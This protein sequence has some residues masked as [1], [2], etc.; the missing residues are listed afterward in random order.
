MEILLANFL[1]IGPFQGIALLALAVIIMLFTSFSERKSVKIFA[2]TLSA[3]SYA[4]TLYLFINNYI[5]TGLFEDFLVVVA[6]KELILL[7]IIIFCALNILFYISFYRFY[8]GGFTRIIIILTF[9]LISASFLVIAS[10]FIIIFVSLVITVFN[11][12]AIISSA[13]PGN[14]ESGEAIGKFGIRTIA[15]PVL[16]FFGFSVLYGSGE[17]KSFLEVQGLETAGDPFILIGTI[18]FA[19]GLFL[20]LFLYPFQGPYLRLARRINGETLPV[21]WFL[22][23]PLGIIMFIKFEVFF[24]IFLKQASINTIAILAAILLLSL[25]GA[26]I[27]ALRTTS[28]KRIIS[29]LMLFS[30]GNIIF[31]KVLGPPGAESGAGLVGANIEGLVVMIIGFMPVCLLMIFTEKGAGSDSILNL[32]GF[33]YR[34]IY[35]SICIILVL[36]WWIAASIYIS[37]LS[38]LFG[39]GSFNYPGTA[40]TI[41]LALYLASWL[42]TAFN[43]SRITFAL[44]SRKREKD[45]LKDIPLPKV[46]YIY[47]SIF[48]LA[49]I[50]TVLLSWQGLLWFGV[51]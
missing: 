23:I 48:T 32:R 47:F 44:F 39:G 27:G 12:F 10:N 3:L 34:K 50:S 36:L 20:F 43:I 40:K 16:F 19:C 13:G 41:I 46:F 15:A 1:K 4:G 29:M 9:T 37:P 7:G 8:K 25:F 33:A 30:V 11:I 18:V 49:A 14:N 42:F 6:L 26:N 21:L 35:I 17:I 31:G 51:S 28:L 22:Y 45:A 2:I 24:D 38:S 5:K